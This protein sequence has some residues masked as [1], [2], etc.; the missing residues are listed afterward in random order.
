MI[1]VIIRAPAQ[2]RT[3]P[4]AYRREIGKVLL[5]VNSKALRKLQK[6]GKV[7]MIVTKAKA[8]EIGQ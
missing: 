2:A 7:K 1:E 4:E 3:D 6:D 5:A 8:G